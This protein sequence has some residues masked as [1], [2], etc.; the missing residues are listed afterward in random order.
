MRDCAAINTYTRQ[1]GATADTCRQCGERQ[2]TA[3]NFPASITIPY[4]LGI[5][6]TVTQRTCPDPW[7]SVGAALGVCEATPVYRTSGA[8]M[9]LASTTYSQSAELAL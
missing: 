3:N 7:S 9:P 2:Y 6:S 8:T 1:L 4:V 5:Q